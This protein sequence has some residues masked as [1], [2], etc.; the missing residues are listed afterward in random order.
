MFKL[1]RY[2]ALFRFDG[3]VRAADATNLVEAHF[4][5]S[6]SIG[7]REYQ[8]VQGEETFFFWN[9][10]IDSD[11]RVTGFEFLLPE[12]TTLRQSRLV[13]HSKNV[14]VD[15]DEV[16]IDLSLG[17]PHKWDCTQGFSSEVYRS[18]DDSADCAILMMNWSGRPAG[19]ELMEDA[20]RLR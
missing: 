11:G 3:S 16:L 12:S 8:L 15:G 7:G 2:Y 6:L 1:C 18:L 4:P 9:E 20:I 13:S 19:F 14:S 10:F 17:D 5:E